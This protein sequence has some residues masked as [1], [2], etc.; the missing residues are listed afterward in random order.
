MASFMASIRPER[1]N[2]VPI[3][4]V[5][6]SRGAVRRAAAPPVSWLR[7]KVVGA[8]PSSTIAPF[9]SIALPPR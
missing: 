9:A 2:S 8:V 1:C 3:A 5:I 4:M 6:G 7:V